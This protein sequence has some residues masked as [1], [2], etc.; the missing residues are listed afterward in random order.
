MN[1]KR[2]KMLNAHKEQKLNGNK[3]KMLHLKAEQMEERA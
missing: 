2:V 3:V 1:L